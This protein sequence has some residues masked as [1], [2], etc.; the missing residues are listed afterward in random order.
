VHFQTVVMNVA[1]LDRSIAF[2]R[3]VFGFTE[4]SRRDQ[5][6]AIA[7]GADDR[8]Q[9]IILR[10][11]GTTGM[12]G[13]ARHT[14][15]RA[16]VLEVE[17]LAELETI[18]AALDRHGA[19]EARRTGDSWEAVFARDPDHTAV[20]AGCSRTSDPIGLAAW[21]ALDESLYGVGE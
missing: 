7:A 11:L 5:L 3:D 8:A 6:A 15:I 17:A 9:V 21:A 2:Y 13:G 10:E 18:A 20:V 16:L 1:D 4:L 19:I 12:T 14:G